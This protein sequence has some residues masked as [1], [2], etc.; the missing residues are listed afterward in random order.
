MVNSKDLSYEVEQLRVEIEQ[1]RMLDFFFEYAEMPS[2]VHDEYDKIYSQ[3]V[4]RAW[5]I[6]QQLLPNADRN[7][8]GLVVINGEKMCLLSHKWWG[9]IDAAIAEQ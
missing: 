4:E 2:E 1:L 5:G 6:T 8:L 3:T 9:H 7:S